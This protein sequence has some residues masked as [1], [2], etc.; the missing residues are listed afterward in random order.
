MQLGMIGLG[1]MGANMAQRLQRGGHDV[2]GFDPSPQ[3]RERASGDGLATLATLEALVDRLE[4][5]RAL[6]MMVPAGAIVDATIDLLLPLL[7]PGD[8]LVDGGN[9]FYGDSQRRAQRL[10]ERDIAYLDVGTSGGVW[11]L[12]EG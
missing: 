2:A 1:R 11:G 12:A 3:A 6:W 5:P 10:A 7:S 8:M 9:S 4:A